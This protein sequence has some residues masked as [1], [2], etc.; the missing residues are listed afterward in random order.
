MK[1]FWL[2][3]GISLFAISCT[4]QRVA[5]LQKT[6]V[7]ETKIY[8]AVD[9]KTMPYRLFVPDG[10][11][12]NK[13]YPLVLWLHGGGA[14]GTDNEKQITEGNTLG[15]TIWTKTEN[16]AKWPSFVLAPQCPVGEWWATNDSEMRPSPQLEMAVELLKELQ[17]Q[18]AIDPER[19]YVGG[20]SMGGYG[21]WSIISEFP[22]MF[23][24]ALP[25]CGGGNRSRAKG[26]VN[27]PVWAFHGDADT[28]VNVSQS[29]A[30][31]DAIRLAGGDPKY[32][33]YKGVG[34]TVWHQA[35]AEPDLVSWV[36]AQKRPERA[37]K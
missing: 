10:Y 35:F 13:K 23:A 4:A 27:V 20:Q 30:M 17:K 9:G 12:K 32:T 7:F 5:D 11:D 34:H 16:Q 29:R 24:A 31:I 36:F 26:L 21:T 14:R 1:S 8:K 37:R 6:N 2:L 33:E 28:A 3:L 15:A 22:D 18:F 25:L 19:L